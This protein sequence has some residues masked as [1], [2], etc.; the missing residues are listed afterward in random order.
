MIAG[1]EAPMLIEQATADDAAEILALQKFAYV[2][3]AE[4]YDDFGI[5]PMTQTLDELMGEFGTH[6]VFKALREGRIVG[7]VRTRLDN[8]TCHVGKLIVHPEAQNLGIGSALMRHLEQFFPEAARFELFTGHKSL[9]NLYLYTKLGYR[10][11]KREQVNDHI[12]LV[13]M[14]KSSVPELSH[15]TAGANLREDAVAEDQGVQQR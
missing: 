2:S 12:W 9:R 5:Q 6:A 11:F 1:I 8:G 10:E 13:Y 4:I 14:E 7:S 3:E 15:E